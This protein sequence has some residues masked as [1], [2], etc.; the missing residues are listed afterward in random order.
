MLSQENIK[1]IQTLAKE[2]GDELKGKLPN[3]DHLH[4]RNSYAHTWHQVKAKMGK[5]YKECDDSQVPEILAIINS[6]RIQ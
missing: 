5:T 4:K 6:L 3:V 2:V 1:L